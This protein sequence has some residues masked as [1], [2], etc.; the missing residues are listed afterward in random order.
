VVDRLPCRK[1]IVPGLNVL[2]VGFPGR[3]SEAF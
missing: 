3:W 1:R 2:Y